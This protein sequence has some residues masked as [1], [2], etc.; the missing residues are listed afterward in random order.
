MGG[1][2]VEKE[3]FTTCTVDSEFSWSVVDKIKEG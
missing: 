3:G 1:N 2:E